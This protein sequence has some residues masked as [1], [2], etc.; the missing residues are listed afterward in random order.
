MD[1]ALAQDEM[2]RSGPAHSPEALARP[3]RSTWMRERRGIEQSSYWVSPAGRHSR[4][5]SRLF[6]IALDA[7][8]WAVSLAGLSSRGRRNVLSPQLIDLALTFPKLPEA[9]DGFRILHLT[10]THLDAV[11]EL[12]MVAAGMLD[13]LEVDLL[14]HTG[15]VLA[16]ADSA[17]EHAIRPLNELLSGVTVQRTAFRRAWQSRPQRNGRGSRGGRLR[18]ADQSLG[19]DRATR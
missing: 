11:P 18:S 1:D 9:F 10:D 4:W 3:D 17:I 8:A 15:D 16:G 14:V 19:N 13:G 2:L 7:F 6:D 5:R 12:A